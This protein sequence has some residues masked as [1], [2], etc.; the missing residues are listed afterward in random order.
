MEDCEAEI[1]IWKIKSADS[2]RKTMDSET[3][4]ANLESAADAQSETV[5]WKRHRSIR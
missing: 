2:K 3:K 1:V 4:N 5:I